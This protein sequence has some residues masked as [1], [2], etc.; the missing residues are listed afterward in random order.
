MGGRAVVKG[1]EMAITMRFRTTNGQ[2]ICAEAGGGREVTA[3]RVAA[4][5]WETF[6]LEQ[7]DQ[8]GGPLMSGQRIA[9][10]TENGHYVCAENG[11]GQELVA[12]RTS[13]GPWETFTIVH[14]D[15]SGGE[16]GD[17]QDVILRTA[18][19]QYCCA[20]GGGGREFLADRTSIGPWETFRVE[21]M[22]SP[23]EPPVDAPAE[24]PPP[25]P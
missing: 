8:Q 12:N 14:A 7:V 15:L 16:I 11:G 10:R 13:V 24:P 2:Y 25:A 3:N 19:G 23:P 17:N 6:T 9:L 21:V 22:A 18:N 5:P 20:E 1:A 4:G